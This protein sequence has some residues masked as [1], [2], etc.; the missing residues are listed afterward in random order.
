M[1]ALIPVHRLLILVLTLCTCLTPARGQGDAASANAQLFDRMGS[2]QRDFTVASEEAAPFLVQGCIWLQSFNHDE[3]IR[4]FKEAARLDPDCAMAWW[5]VAFAE[6]PNYNDPVMTERRNQAAW[7][8]LQQA[9]ARIN[10]T[11]PWE[12]A[13][14]EALSTRYAHPFPEDRTHLE[15]AYAD[16]MA[17]VWQTYL[18][19]ADIGAYYAEAMMVQKPWALYTPDREPVE[20]TDKIVATLERVLELNPDHPGACHLYIH[21]VEQ[22]KT[23]E[24]A[25]PA[26]DRLCNLVPAS[27]HMRHMPSHI[28]TRVDQWDRSIEQNALAM[29]AD[30]RYRQLSPNQGIQHMYMVHNNHILAYSAMMV[31]R[32][33]EALEAARRMWSDPSMEA[34]HGVAPLVDAWMC[35]LYDVQKR[36]GMWDELLEEDAPPDYMPITLAYWRAHRAIAHAALKDFENALADYAEFE[37][38]YNN[39][40]PLDQLFPGWTHAM[41]QSRLNAIRHFVPGEIALQR[42]AYD[43][44]IP[45]LERAVQAED[46][47]GY[48]GEPPEYL[49]P[50]RHTLGAVYFKVGRHKDAE[51]VYREDLAE[52]P[53]NSWSLYGLSRALIAQGKTNEGEEAELAYLK[54]WEKADFPRLKTTCICI[55]SL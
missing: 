40:P 32:Q 39:P 35:S 18:N 36:F 42:G 37:R 51:R 48:G 3:A 5:G 7:D 29:E 25:L 11:A 16:A 4:S 47:L 21:S 53:G 54:S 19:D 15:Q 30:E 46:E 43:L 45:H 6:G 28:Y 22:S 17:K 44:A 2:W 12:R 52:F 26:A 20:G 38:L 8:A 10:N 1:R 14:I 31:G 33:Q 41:Y 27:G 55:P 9:L 50:I 23:P 49:Q 24:R 13:L 34:L